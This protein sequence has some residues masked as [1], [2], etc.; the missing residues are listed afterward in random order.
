MFG[1]GVP[2]ASDLTQRPPGSQTSKFLSH[3]GR[4][5]AAVA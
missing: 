4:P 1:Y 3:R 5:D 2:A